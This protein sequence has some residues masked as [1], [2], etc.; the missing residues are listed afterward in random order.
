MFL[1][2]DL[3]ISYNNSLT[4]IEGLS[5]ITSISGYLDIAQNSSLTSLNGLNNI[6]SIT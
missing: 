1:G 4:N 2:S 6:T 5:G 3:T